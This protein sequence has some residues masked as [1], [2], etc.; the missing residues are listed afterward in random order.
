MSKSGPIHYAIVTVVSQC[1]PSKFSVIKAAQ[2]LELYLTEG[3]P[4]KTMTLALH[5]NHFAV[6]KKLLANQISLT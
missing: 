4:A 3:K 2:D 1:F 6:Y 5:F